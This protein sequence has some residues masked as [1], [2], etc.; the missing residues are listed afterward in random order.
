MRPPA[1]PIAAS[2][3][4]EDV[5]HPGPS[6]PSG[7]EIPLSAL[8]SGQRRTVAR[9][10]GDAGE[11]TREGVLPGTHLRL[12]S[13]VMPGGPVVV[14]VGRARLAI[15]AD[16]AAHVL[17]RPNDDPD[18]GRAEQAEPAEAGPA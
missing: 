12:V 7:P 3:R 13:Q 2:T 18:E 11:L 16:L 1:S 10:T 8:R 9:V 5:A 15:A 17:L 4:V 14:Q 6:G